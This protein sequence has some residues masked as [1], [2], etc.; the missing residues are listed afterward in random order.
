MKG[1]V[2][3]MI[4][5]EI[6]NYTKR[7]KEKN[8]LEDIDCR[9]EGGKIYGLIGRNGSGKTMMLRAIAGLIYPTR[10]S[11]VINEKVLH[12]DIDFPENTGIIIENTEMLPQYDGFTNLKLLAKVSKKAT[13]NDITAALQRVGLG[14]VGKKKVK[15]YSLGMRQKLSIAQ[16]IF[17]NPEILLLDEPTNA[18]DEKS[19]EEVRKILLDYK[20]NGA[21]I[22]LASHNKEDIERLSDEIIE[23]DNGRLI[24]K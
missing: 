6:K 12:K 5:V 21:L 2:K 13:D 18:L 19:V 11:V 10:G 22:I 24:K 9:F 23:M 17:E 7:I 8:V 1:M 4:T 16:A 15:A 3:R 20:K 14:D